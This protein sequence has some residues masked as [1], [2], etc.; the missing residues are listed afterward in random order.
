[1]IPSLQCPFLQPIL[2]TTHT[3][4]IC[5]TSSPAFLVLQTHPF[6]TITSPTLYCNHTTLHYNTPT[7]VPTPLTNTFTNIFSRN[8]GDLLSKCLKPNPLTT[9]IPAS[10]HR[11]KPSQTQLKT[12]SISHSSNPSFN[13]YIV[14]TVKEVLSRFHFSHPGTAVAQ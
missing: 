13:Q 1:T 4:E 11:Y 12:H 6:H 14:E 7:P 3:V 5:K 2:S 10:I 8:L 9:T